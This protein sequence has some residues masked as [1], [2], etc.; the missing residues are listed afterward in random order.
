M[1]LRLASCLALVAGVMRR[2]SKSKNPFYVLLII[3]GIAF[4]LTATAYG[5]MVTRETSATQT[6]AGDSTPG[7][8]PLMSWMRHHGN[9][10]LMVELLLLAICTFG[11]IG[12]DEFWQ[13]RN[14]TGRKST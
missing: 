10:A 1:R 8:H 7:E 4:A 5:I 2:S 13:R 11:A 14:A 9:T 12:T 6:A 3:T